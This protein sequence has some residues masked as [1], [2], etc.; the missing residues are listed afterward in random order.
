M[1]WHINN[2]DVTDGVSGFDF[3]IY[4]RFP[5]VDDEDRL[6][7]A[8][9]ERAWSKIVSAQRQL[10]RSNELKVRDQER[11][12]IRRKFVECFIETPSTSLKT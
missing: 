5:E 1:L 10:P 12:V 6:S 4:E 11:A 2:Y 9:R 3:R 7:R 8:P